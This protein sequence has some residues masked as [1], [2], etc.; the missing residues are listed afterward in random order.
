MNPLVPI[1]LLVFSPLWIYIFSP[2]GDDRFEFRA[3]LTVLAVAAAA[4]WA[5][6]QNPLALMLCA[7]LV[8]LYALQA[9]SRSRSW[10][11]AMKYWGT[12]VFEDQAN[13]R[14]RN[15][16]AGA[17]TERGFYTEARAHFEMVMEKGERIQARQAA[18][19]LAGVLCRQGEFDKAEATARAGIASF[20]AMAMFSNA[21]A[22]AQMMRSEFDAAVLS[23]NDAIAQDPLCAAFFMNRAEC[24]MYLGNHDS[25]RADYTEVQRLTKLQGGMGL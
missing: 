19:N 8:L 17:L 4:G 3:S 5:A 13:D 15:Y 20:G 10:S 25:A 1:V 7:V 9:R 16:Y 14:A 11:T 22:A 24:F 2:A 6:E 12:A 23:L 21:I 18:I